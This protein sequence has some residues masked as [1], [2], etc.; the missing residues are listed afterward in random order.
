MGY[1]SVDERYTCFIY[2]EFVSDNLYKH[3]KND[4]NSWNDWWFMWWY[5]T[6]FFQTPLQRLKTE[7]MTMNNNNNFNSTHLF[8]KDYK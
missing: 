6:R 4:E 8:K 2:A 3:I 7:A 5:S 1:D